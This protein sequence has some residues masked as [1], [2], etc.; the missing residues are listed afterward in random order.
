LTAQTLAMVAP[1][2]MFVESTRIDAESSSLTILLLEGTLATFMSS[3]Y[4]PMP[5]LV[6]GGG[7]G[8]WWRWRVVPNLKGRVIT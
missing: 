3:S 1:A 5:K 2:A 8:W 7:W 4:Q 6:V